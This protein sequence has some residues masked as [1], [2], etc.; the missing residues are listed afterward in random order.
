MPQVGVLQRSN[1]LFEGLRLPKKLDL[2]RTPLAKSVAMLVSMLFFH[3]C[4][5][6]STKE[7]WAVV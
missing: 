2:R 7:V 6:F 1:F 3:L 4:L 5:K